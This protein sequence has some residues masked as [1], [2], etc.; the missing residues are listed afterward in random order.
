MLKF[1]S[2]FVCLFLFS[3]SAVFAEP[4]SQDNLIRLKKIVTAGRQTNY[5]GTF[6]YQS[7]NYVETSRIT[8]VLEGENEHERLEGLDGEKT[9][10]I[11][12]NSDI[13]CYFGGS[14]V[15]V[16]KSEGARTFP[17]L[18]P[19][20]LSL[21]QENYQVSNGDED[22]VAG[23]HAHSI[24]FQP[25]DN[26]RYAHKMWANSDSGL[27]LKAVVMDDHGR[28]IEQYAFTQLQ[29]GGEIDRKWMLPN[30]TTDQ[31]NQS[32]SDKSASNKPGPLPA[33]SGWKVYF[34]PAGFKK[35]T[36]VSRHLRGN[37]F[38]VIHLVYS[39]GL[40]G[41]SVFIEKM[42]P[43]SGIRQGLFSKGVIHI[44]TKVLDGHLLTVVGE[45]PPRTVI[46]VAESVRYGGAE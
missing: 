38:P 27:L 7:G 12:K 24:I 36:E 31:K 6:I 17:A 43:R 28:I 33:K 45:V 26:M 10:I 39:D 32:V 21:L 19:E 35:I 15:M 37:D 44:F 11:R 34:L 5:I 2:G 14:K 16:A 40:A 25:T 1:G 22:R 13:Q 3:G 4:I 18:L 41:I 30:R 23:F 8:H 46:Q 42:G 29:I 20:Q 9:E